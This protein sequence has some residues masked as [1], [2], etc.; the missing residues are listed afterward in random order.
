LLL[1]KISAGNPLLVIY[2][3]LNFLNFTV[4]SSTLGQ[5]EDNDQQFQQ[6]QGSL[7]SEKT[8]IFEDGNVELYVEKTGFKRQTRFTLD[9]HLFLIKIHFKNKM[10]VLFSTIMGTLK[11]AFSFMIKSLRTYYGS[12]KFA[13]AVKN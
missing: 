8:K 4:A 6:G 13:K 9:D 10:P 5:L 3:S 7:F 1:I 12:G 11:E 2:N